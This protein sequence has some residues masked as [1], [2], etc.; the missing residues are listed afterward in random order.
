MNFMAQKFD[1]YAKSQHMQQHDAA[2]PAPAKRIRSSV[3]H[4]VPMGQ[5]V[6]TPSTKVR[7]TP[8]AIYEI[9]SRARDTSV[10]MKAALIF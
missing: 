3:D 5:V 7:M 9:F 10:S 1:L 2:R 6:P 8:D 4:D